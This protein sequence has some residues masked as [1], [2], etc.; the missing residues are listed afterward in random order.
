MP[1]LMTEC[2]ILP[3]TVSCEKVC[4]LVSVLCAIKYV[5]DSSLQPCRLAFIRVRSLE[6]VDGRTEM[7]SCPRLPFRHC[8][9]HH[10]HLLCSLDL[11]R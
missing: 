4:V 6:H 5:L 11:I 1:Y 3:V 9:Q 7:P 8:F 10:L 2:M